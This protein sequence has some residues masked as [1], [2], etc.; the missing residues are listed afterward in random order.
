[1]HE[2]TS[3]DPALAAVLAEL[4]RLG[5]VSPDPLAV[6]LDVAREQLRRQYAYLSSNPPPMTRTQELRVN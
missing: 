6:P 3:L 5:H 1:M 4:K 2:H